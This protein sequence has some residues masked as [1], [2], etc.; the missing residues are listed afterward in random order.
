MSNRQ[1]SDP[2]NSLHETVRDSDVGDLIYFLLGLQELLL[3]NVRDLTDESLFAMSFVVIKYLLEGQELVMADE[4][5]Q[6]DSQIF[7]VQE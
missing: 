5:S 1:I 2:C 7:G 4:W 6:F 3:E